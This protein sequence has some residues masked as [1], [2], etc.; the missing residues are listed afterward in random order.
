MLDTSVYKKLA[1]ND[2][3]AAAGH[4]GGIV[5]PKDIAEFFPPLP[6]VIA[7]GGPTVDTRLKADLFVDGVR[8]AAIETRYQHQTWGGTRTAERRLTDNLGPLRNEATED[9][10][11]LFTKDLLDDEYIQIHLLRKA[12]AEYDLLNARIG[13]ARWGPVDPSNPP[14]SITE[15]QI[16][17]NDIE[18]VAENAPNVFGVKRQEAEVVTMRKARDRAFRNK[19]LDQYDFR[20]A[21][22]GRKFVSPHSPRTVGLDAAHVVPVHASGSD[23]PANGLPLSKELH[24]AFDKGLIGVGENRRIVVPEDVG[25]LN[26]NEF[27]LGLNG[28]QIR[29]AELERLRVS[30]EALA[31]HRKNVLLA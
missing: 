12:T 20:C 7:K 2:T 10:I 4:Q 14:V 5:I 26:G 25:A 27:L 21:F 17:E 31:W 28:D 29:E 6:A 22:T 30:E 16:A 13:T 8:V 15:I 24:W 19:V 1:H 18:E 11:V 23:H 3:G 9:D